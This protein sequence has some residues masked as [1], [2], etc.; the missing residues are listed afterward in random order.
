MIKGVTGK[1]LW[2]DLT[3]GTCTEEVVPEEVY[4]KHMPALVWPLTTST[5]AFLPGL[6]LWVQTIFWLLCQGC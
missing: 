3:L 2:V 1:I 6:I 5:I 4:E